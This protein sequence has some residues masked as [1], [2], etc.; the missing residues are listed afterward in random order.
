[1][2]AFVVAADVDG[3]EVVRLTDAPK[4][5]SAGMKQQ[6]RLAKSLSRK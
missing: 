6:R 2:T 4:A 1:L 5:L 3:R